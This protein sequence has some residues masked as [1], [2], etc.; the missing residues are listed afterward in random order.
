MPVPGPLVMN[1]QERRVDKRLPRV[2][3]VAVTV[4]SASGSPSIER[5][6]FFCRTR[7]LSASGMKMILDERLPGSALVELHV[8]LSEPLGAFK[9]RGRVAWLSEMDGGFYAVGVEF[10]ERGTPQMIQWG[11][12]IRKVLADG[13]S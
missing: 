4:V 8:A 9:L 10:L 7:D 13:D 2:D 3:S 6:T 5:R 12:A 1:D 11:A